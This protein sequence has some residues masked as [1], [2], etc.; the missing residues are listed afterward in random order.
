MV[1]VERMFEVEEA[2]TYADAEWMN[3]LIFR[4]SLSG[5]DFAKTLVDV[6]FD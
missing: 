6:L 3:V 1:E 5:P 4:P 2:V